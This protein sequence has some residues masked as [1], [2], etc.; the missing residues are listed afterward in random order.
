MDTKI[1]RERLIT[2]LLETPIFEELEPA[3][4]MEIVHIV[5]VAQYQAGDTVFSEGDGGDAWYPQHQRAR[6]LDQP[7]GQTVQRAIAG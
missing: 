5:E 3:E 1:T 7:V 2:F 6:K 4:L